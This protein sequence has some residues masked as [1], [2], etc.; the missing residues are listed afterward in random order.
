M[1]LNLTEGELHKACENIKE[2]IRKFAKESGCKGL[3]LGLSG[4]IDS[5]V[6]LKLASDS[7]VNVKALLLPEEELTS[8]EDMEDAEKLAQELRVEY[9]IIGIKDVL[10]AIDGACSFEA[11]RKSWGNVK[12]RVRM[13]LL[14]LTANLERRLVMGTGNRTEIMLG[15]YTK[16]GDGGADFFPIG[17]LY[18]TQVRQLAKHIRIPERIMGKVPSACLWEGQTDEDELGLDYETIDRIL[19]K[20]LDEKKSANAVA[21]EVKC[22]LEIVESLKKRVDAN[23]HKRSLSPVFKPL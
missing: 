21:A 20:L 11:D 4:G 22:R 16:H 2:G 8:D 13:T 14:Y 19:Y 1:G 7:G 3:V 15:Y 9:D 6:V 18:K 5:A 17:G 23:M 10:D 12:P